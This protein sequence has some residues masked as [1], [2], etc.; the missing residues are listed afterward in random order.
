MTNGE[1]SGSTLEHTSVVRELKQIG[2]IDRKDNGKSF[3]AALPGNSEW[4]AENIRYVV[5]VQE[6]ST[7]KVLAVNQVSK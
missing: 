2:T 1:N 6:N 5:F 3:D 7:L 4:K